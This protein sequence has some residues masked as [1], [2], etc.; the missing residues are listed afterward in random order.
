MIEA[1]VR[2]FLES[3]G[4]EAYVS[5]PETHGEAFAIVGMTGASLANHING[6]RITVQSY[7]ERQAQA[8]EL[9]DRVI[10]LM[11]YQMPAELDLISR[12]AL[13]TSYPQTDLRTKQ[14]RY[15][16]VFYVTYMEDLS[17]G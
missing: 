15:Q 9:N 1:I 7:G 16:A 5:I 2:D 17:N 11:V 6:A 12:V 13:E 4:V 10:G 14:Y 8:G 3:K